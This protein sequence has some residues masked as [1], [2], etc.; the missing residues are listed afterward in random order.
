MPVSPFLLRPLLW[1]S[2]L[3]LQAVASGPFCLKA[4]WGAL[5]GDPRADPV[6]RQQ[7]HPGSSQSPGFR[8]SCD[9]SPGV[10]SR[11]AAPQSPGP[12]RHPAVWQG[13]HTG[14]CDSSFSL[15][16]LFSGGHGRV[17]PCW[18]PVRGQSTWSFPCLSSWG[19]PTNL[20][21]KDMFS[22]FTGKKWGLMA[23]QVT[24]PRPRRTAHPDLAGHRPRP[25]WSQ[26][27]HPEGC[28]GTQ[29]AALTTDLAIRSI[30]RTSASPGKQILSGPKLFVSQ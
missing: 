3:R 9:S 4:P 2:C 28:A 7:V 17:I 30:T 12:S 25:G 15:G 1:P 20:R 18:T 22:S 16:T 21:D 27:L 19:P 11:D 23:D 13:A 29:G 6:Q 10:P 24:S 26:H 5:Q 14:P 8:P